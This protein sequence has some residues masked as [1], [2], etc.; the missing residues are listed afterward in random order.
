M[1]NWDL[2]IMMP[3]FLIASF[4][5]VGF[6][7]YK[8]KI[9]KRTYLFLI[10]ITIFWFAVSVIGYQLTNYA[11]SSFQSLSSI[12]YILMILFGSSFFVLIFK[13]LATFL[14][15]F[16]KLRKLWTTI[17]YSLLI[18]IGIL[19]SSIQIDKV[20]IIFLSIIYAILLSTSTIHNLILN[21]QHYYRI[22]TLPVTWICY[23]FIGVGSILGIYFCSLETEV[24]KLNNYLFFNIFV[25]LAG[26]FVLIFS[27]TYFKENK[28]LSGSFDQEVIIQLPKKNNWNFLIIYFLTL[29]I[30]LTYS[31]SNSLT[32]KTFM[33]LKLLE[34]GYLKEEIQTLIRVF[35]YASVIPSLLV[36]YFIFK[37]LLKYFGQRYFL[38]INLFGLAIMY[39][40]LAF[41]SNPYIF[42]VL[43]IFIGIFYNQIIYTLFSFCMFWNYRAPSNPVTGF[44]GTALFLGKVIIETTEGAL[45]KDHT[46]IFKSLDD[47]FD[48]N[49]HETLREN[50]TGYGNILSITFSICAVI[51]FIMILIYYYTSKKLIADFVNYRLAT[52][53]LKSILKKRV[54]QKTKTQIDVTK[55]KI[56][57]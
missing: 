41:T 31:L 51:V 53:N 22:N 32:T 37:Y 19:L 17:S 16:I 44:F 43:N 49:N 26:L 10:E 47:I 34:S 8:E 54:I 20:F 15:G 4:F 36:S 14:T 23:I 28:N 33:S 12:S 3:I 52:Q 7:I 57:N 27:L 25:I 2:I 35:D 55:L 29:L 50:L 30:S 18:L 39:S 38:M 9:K 13:P 24:L 56:K 45:I 48:I 42:I 1:Q 11:A 5:I 46:S 40:I 6:V 21:E